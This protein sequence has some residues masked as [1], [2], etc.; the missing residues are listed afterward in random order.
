[1]LTLTDIGA[2]GEISRIAMHGRIINSNMLSWANA[3]YD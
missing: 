3:I 2:D 1:M